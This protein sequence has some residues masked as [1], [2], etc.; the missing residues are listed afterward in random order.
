MP[1]YIP[2]FTIDAFH[3]LVANRQVYVKFMSRHRVS[4]IT[5]SGVSFPFL[6]WLV[7]AMSSPRWV[8]Q[9]IQL[10]FFRYSAA[11]SGVSFTLRF[12]SIRGFSC[13]ILISFASIIVTFH[14]GVSSLVIQ[15][16]EM[17]IYKTDEHHP[18]GSQYCG[19]RFERAKYC[20]FGLDSSDS[21]HL[22][23]CLQAW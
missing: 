8:R 20:T 21:I 3:F 23:S 15:I 9:T 6:R 11:P 7:E 4:C 14:Q 16:F 13:D 22:S 19:F 2:S 5:K 18:V 1:F 17:W 12:W 10:Y